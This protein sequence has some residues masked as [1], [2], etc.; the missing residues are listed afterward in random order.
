MRAVKRRT[1]EPM[2]A[3]ET[4]AEF[5]GGDLPRGEAGE[6]VADAIDLVATDRDNGDDAELEDGVNWAGAT[7]RLL[8]SFAEES[9]CSQERPDYEIEP[10]YGTGVHRAACHLH[11]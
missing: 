9:I 1:F 3:A 10:Q 6:I 8:E 2:T 11:R 4:R 5:F 7:E